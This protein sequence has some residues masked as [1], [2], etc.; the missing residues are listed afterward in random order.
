MSDIPINRPVNRIDPPEIEGEYLVRA[1]Y[2]DPWRKCEVVEYGD[3]IIAEIVDC[4]YTIP[5]QN[6][7]LY[8]WA[9]D[10]FLGG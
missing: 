6:F 7:G 1:S 10:N 9:E 5:H 4:H 2:I 8:L 3:M